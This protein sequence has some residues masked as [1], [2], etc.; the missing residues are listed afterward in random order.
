MKIDEGKL[1]QL[2]GQMLNDLGGA[3]SVAMVRMGDVRLTRTVDLAPYHW[4][5]PPAVDNPDPDEPPAS[6]RCHKPM[7]QQSRS[8]SLTSGRSLPHHPIRTLARRAVAA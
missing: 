2:V 3:A 1:H 8:A 5:F 4:L 7:A 6:R